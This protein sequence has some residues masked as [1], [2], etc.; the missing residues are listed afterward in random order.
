[1][2]TETQSTRINTDFHGSF[3]NIISAIIR[4]RP[5]NP[6]SHSKQKITFLKKPLKKHTQEFFYQ[7]QFHQQ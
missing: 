1:M 7:I 5:C 6:R 3:F 4:V 2:E